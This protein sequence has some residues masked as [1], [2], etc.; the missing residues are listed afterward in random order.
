MVNALQRHAAIV[1]QKSLREGFGL[2]VTEA[3]WKARP[4]VASAVSGIQ[5]QIEHGVSGML[6]KDPSDLDAFAAVIRQLLGN[7]DLGE[8]LGRN[9]R[10]RVRQ[11]YLGIR[12]LTQFA[13]LIERLDIQTSGEVR[14]GSVNRKAMR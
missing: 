14:P 7:P 8:R 9:A 12:S 11:Q 10:Q 1:V 3:M 5:D 2:T 6:L 4:V 13:D